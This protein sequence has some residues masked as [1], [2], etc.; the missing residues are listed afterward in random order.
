MKWK[1][2]LD[3]FRSTNNL[4]NPQTH[5]NIETGSPAIIDMLL[6]EVEE[7]RLAILAND[8]HETINACNDLITLSANHLGQMKYDVDLTM[9]ETVK[10]IL[11]RTGAINTATGKWTKFTTSEAKALWYTPDYSTCKVSN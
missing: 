3:K 4:T 1:Q 11:S 5:T 6:E 7:L 9:K 10:E 2:G 8:T